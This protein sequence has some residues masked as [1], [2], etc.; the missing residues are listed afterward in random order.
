[1]KYYTIPALG[2]FFLKFLYERDW[3]EMKIF[4][5]CIIPLLLIFLVFPLVFLESYRNALFNYPNVGG[6]PLIIRIIPISIVFIVYTIF[7]LKNAENYEIIIVSTIV[8]ACFLIFSY[9]Y[10]RWFQFIIFYGILTQREFSR[11]SLNIGFI[12]KEIKIDNHVL[13]FFLSF[14]GVGIAFLLILFRIS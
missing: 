9:T 3:K 1:V 14:I 12:K 7:R 6:I 8:T 2:F 13:T 10:I 11:K 4:L 5:I